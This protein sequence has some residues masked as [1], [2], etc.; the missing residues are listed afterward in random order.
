M[1]VVAGVVVE[2][3]PGRAGAVAGRIGAIPSVAVHGDDGDRR[4]AVVFTA[5]D[6]ETLETLGEGLVALDDE[7]VGVFPTFAGIDAEP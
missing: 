1:T 2:T 5:E 3:L 6:G 7:I 4:I